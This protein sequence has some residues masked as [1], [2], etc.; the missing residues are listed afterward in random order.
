MHPA[1]IAPCY[2]SFWHFLSPIA[3][4]RGWK[5]LSYNAL[6]KLPTIYFRTSGAGIKKAHFSITKKSVLVISV[7]GVLTPAKNDTARHRILIVRFYMLA[8]LYHEYFLS[9][10]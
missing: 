6:Q 1:T 9:S 7:Y 8:E 5:I 10:N 3:N 2:C 4:T